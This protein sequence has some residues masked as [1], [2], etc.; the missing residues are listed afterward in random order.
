MDAGAFIHYGTIGATI[1]LGAAGIAL[2]EGMIARDT[3]EA[4]YE[5]PQAQREISR[6]SF[7]AMALTE[8][9][10]ILALTIMIIL[11]L[12]VKPSLPNFEAQAI[13]RLGILFA[14]GC[15]GFAVGIVSSMPAG[16]A[17]RSVARQPLIANK[18]MNLMLL[19]MTIIQTPIIFGFI[20]GLLIH[21]SVN[22]TTTVL[23]AWRFCAAGIAIGI[24][25]IGPVI[26]QG[27]FAKVAC[28]SLGIRRQAYKRIVSF[29]LFSQALIETP[30]LLA[31]LISFIL[32]LTVTVT[33]YL[34][35]TAALVAAATIGIGTLVPGISAGL[36]AAK[37]CQAM[38][39]HPEQQADITRTSLL[40]QTFLD[41]LPIYCLVVSLTLLLVTR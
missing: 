11:F 36:V 6:L 16:A 9:A 12:T 31:C 40:V 1:A 19:T 21:T 14:V 28:A 18:I 2:G 29:A 33:N 23:E 41:T 27:I 30:I 35:L 13:A 26:G 15:S 8:T 17:V 20:I 7:I 4:Q 10:A 3:M 25:S 37:S 32:I 34:Q 22:T 39:Q 24:G 5:Q 38:T